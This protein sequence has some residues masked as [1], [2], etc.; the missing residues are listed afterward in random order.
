VST[1]DQGHAVNRLPSADSRFRLS[2][3]TSLIS[4]F[5]DASG[6]LCAFELSQRYTSVGALCAALARLPG[7]HFEERRVSVWSQQIPNR[8]TFKGRL[9]EVSAPH[10]D[11]RIAPVEAGAIYQESNELLRLVIEHLAPKWRS[12]ARSRFIRI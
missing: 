4:E 12:R 10:E 1:Q 8:F 5:R 6:A 2:L 11:V 9:Y 7:I 3:R